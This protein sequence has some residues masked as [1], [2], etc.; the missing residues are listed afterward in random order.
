MMDRRQV[1]SSEFGVR[2]S[3]YALR[4]RFANGV[5]K[6]TPQ[7]KVGRVLASGN[8]KDTRTILPHQSEV[9]LICTDYLLIWVYNSAIW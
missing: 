7:N 5:R 6:F 8:K 2:S 9:R 1:R 4:A 3:E